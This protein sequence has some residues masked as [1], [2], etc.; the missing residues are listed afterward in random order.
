VFIKFALIVGL[1]FLSDQCLLLHALLLIVHFRPLQLK[2]NRQAF[3]MKKMLYGI[4]LDRKRPSHFDLIFS[5][6]FYKF[7]KRD[8]KF[9]KRQK[10]KYRTDYRSHSPHASS[11]YLSMTHSIN[12]QYVT[13]L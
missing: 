2:S 8:K 12:I 4:S 1:E 10:A 11:A 5:I 9:K 3:V 13:I 6:L 7:I